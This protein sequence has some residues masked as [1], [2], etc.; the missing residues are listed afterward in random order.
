MNSIITAAPLT[1]RRALRAVLLGGAAIALAGC[2]TPTTGSVSV[3]VA[4]LQAI[5]TEVQAILP[6]IASAVSIP[7]ATLAEI[8]SI[9]SAITSALSAISSA[10]STLTGASVL[11]QVE[12]YINALAPLILPFLSAI[13]GGGVI[14]LIVAAL[15]AIEAALNFISS[16]T[17]QALSLASAAPALAS[18]R[19]RGPAAVALTP[20]VSQLYL[21]LLIARAGGAASGRFQRR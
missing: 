11:A 3:W 19:L 18:A 14:G 4:G 5:E 15:P 20:A 21:N 6:Q 17:S 16:L 12:G 2:G 8:T 9:L 13:P 10:S 7:A 1:R